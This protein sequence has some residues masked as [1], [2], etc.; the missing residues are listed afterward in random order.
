MENLDKKLENIFSAKALIGFNSE[1]KFIEEYNDFE[2]TEPF[3]LLDI[4]EKWILVNF[5]SNNKLLDKYNNL[6]NKIKCLGEAAT[7]KNNGQ[8]KGQIKDRITE[9]EIFNLFE[10]NNLDIQNNNDKNGP[11][12]KI[13]NKNYRFE[14]KTVNILK[15]DMVK[16]NARILSQ[17]KCGEEAVIEEN[18]TRSN[19]K[20]L[21]KEIVKTG[22]NG[23]QVAIINPE[24]TRKK[25]LTIRD[26]YKR[27]IIDA[28]DKFSNDENG[29]VIIKIM[30]QYDTSRNNLYLRKIFKDLAEEYN[31]K[32]D[33]LFISHS[34]NGLLCTYDIIFVNR[35]NILDKNIVL[36]F[37]NMLTDFFM[38]TQI[39]LH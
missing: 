4:Y 21:K 11:E 22:I 25:N 26:A 16:D 23:A 34:I 36:Y 38:K 19:I 24:Y 27:N 31:K 15:N 20:G 3:L 35:T 5:F 37:K 1:V 33:G 30:P 32:C 39:Y 28:L 13:V 9:V 2:Y 18:L 12:G 14:V 6:Y 10:K 29:L 8:I 17:L 7:N